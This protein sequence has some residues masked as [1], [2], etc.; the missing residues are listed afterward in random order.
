[1][2]LHPD[3]DAV[4]RDRIYVSSRTSRQRTECLQTKEES[5]YGRS[6]WPLIRWS[7]VRFRY[8]LQQQGVRKYCPFVCY[9]L[10]NYFEHPAQI[11]KLYLSEFHNDVAA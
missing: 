6:H 8:D 9:S 11:F 2:V 4:T 7:E 3:R 10:K 1:M 5:K